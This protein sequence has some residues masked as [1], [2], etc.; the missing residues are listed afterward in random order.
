MNSAKRN[1]FFYPRK[2]ALPSTTARLAQ[3]TSA[4]QDIQNETV[5]LDFKSI[6]SILYFWGYMWY[7]WNINNVLAGGK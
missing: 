7:N 2:A 3:C 5:S 6:N 4:E 1:R